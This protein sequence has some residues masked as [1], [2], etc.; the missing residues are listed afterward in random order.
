MLRIVIPTFNRSAKLERVLEWYRAEKL[1]AAIVILDASDDPAH[2][3]ANRRVVEDYG[4]A[5]TRIDA[6]G[7]EDILERLHTYLVGIEDDVIVLGNDEDA[8]LPEFLTAAASFLHANPDYSLVTGR[9]LTSARGLGPL[10]RIS[11]WTDTFLGMDVDDADPA[12][13]IVN[14]QRMNSGG[15]P[16]LFWSVRRREVFVRSCAL[17]RELKYASAH[18]LIDQINSCFVGKVAV[19]AEPMLLR[20]ESKVAY[21]KFRNRDE[22]RL[23]IG[24][25]DLDA[26]DAQAHRDLDGSSALAVR[27][28]TSWFRLRG[29]DDSYHSRLFSRSYCRFEPLADQDTRG[30][31]WVAA[32]IRRTSSAGVLLSQLFAYC[33]YRIVMTRAGRGARF[34]RMTR[35]FAVNR[36]SAR[37]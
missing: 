19:R 15:V 25:Q 8:F 24:A 6:L 7:Q 1:A 27:I 28:V 22:G 23:Y 13:R 9:Y 17:A 26:I 32:F 33:Y 34:R 14:F 18:E 3:Q 30:L 35:N 5:A 20:D 11:Y 16:P 12:Q 29:A 37:K 10:R 21:K 31:R 4:P 36:T 2:Q